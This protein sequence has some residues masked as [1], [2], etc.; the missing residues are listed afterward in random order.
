[1]GLQCRHRDG[2]Q[3]GGLMLVCYQCGEEIELEG[4]VVRKDTCPSCHAWLHSCR[5]CRFHDPAVNN[6]C[7]EP[8]AEWVST[9]ES[10]NFCEYFEPG[11]DR[12]PVRSRQ[13][14]REAFDQ[15]FKK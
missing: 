9:K 12:G 3:E 7:R 5:H 4:K 11:G 14:G 15:L 2:E 8:A 6:Q 10:N 13:L 1:M